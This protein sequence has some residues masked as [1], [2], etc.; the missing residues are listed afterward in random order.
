MS[1]GAFLSVVFIVGYFIFQMHKS[2]IKKQNKKKS[3]QP[4]SINQVVDNAK[5][6]ENK[7]TIEKEINIGNWSHENFVDKFGDKLDLDYIRTPYINPRFS[8]TFTN[9][10][11]LEGFL[12]VTKD[13]LKFNSFEYGRKGDEQ[14]KE[15][16]K[17]VNISMKNSKGDIF[18]GTLD[19]NASIS[20]SLNP[21][22]WNRLNNYFRKSIGHIKIILETDLTTHK[23]EININGYTKNRSKLKYNY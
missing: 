22:E 15:F 8:N 3:M 7:K 5:I 10:S 23:F 18:L 1:K 20:K 21:N 4:V 9:N 12:S 11:E 6:I 17:K 13:K 2:D 14:P 16:Y 19:K